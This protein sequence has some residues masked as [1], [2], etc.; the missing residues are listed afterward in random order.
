MSQAYMSHHA[1]S[2]CLGIHR[3]SHAQ[4][5]LVLQGSYQEASADGRFH[6]EPGML[7]I[8]PQWHQHL[9]DFGGTGAVVLNLPLSGV[10]SYSVFRVKDVEALARLARHCPQ[11]AALAACEEAAAVSPI[12]PAGWLVKFTALLAGDSSAEI[13]Q[14]AATCGVSTGHAIRACKRWFGVSP[15]ALRRERRLQHAIILL[16]T[17]ATPAEAAYDTGFSDQ[18]HLTRLLKRATGLTPAG[19]GHT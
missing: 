10:D 13:A 4:A 16:R 2:E 11:Q 19:F 17:G 6:C 14:L 18:P 3:H 7:T 5:A 9:D 1:S 8:H 12:A 15:A